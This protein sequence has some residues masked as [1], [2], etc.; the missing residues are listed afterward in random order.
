[1]PLHL[2]STQKVI[3]QNIAELIRSGRSPAQ[4]AAISYKKAGKSR[5]SKRPRLAEYVGT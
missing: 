3:S 2:G 5:E 1:M 4:A